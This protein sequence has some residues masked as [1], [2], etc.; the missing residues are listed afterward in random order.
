MGNF[1]G[2]QLP[3]RPSTFA[4]GGSK[5]RGKR[6]MAFRTRR[7]R[8]RVPV[9]WLPN[10]G[11]PALRNT[12]STAYANFQENPAV[13]EHHDGFNPA[14]NT[15]LEFPLL[16]DNPPLVAETGGTLVNYEKQS[17]NFTEDIGYSL[18][19]IVGNIYVS[20]QQIPTE[21]V[22]SGIAPAWLVTAGLIVRRVDSETGLPLA[23][24]EDEDPIAIQNNQDPWIW[25]RNWILGSFTSQQSITSTLAN[26]VSNFPPSNAFIG[27]GSVRE[28][29]FVD[30]KT[31]RWVGPEERLIL[32]MSF[33]A[34]PLDVA[35]DPNNFQLT[36][37]YILFVH[38]VLGTKRYNRGNRNN[39]SR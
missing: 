7:R 14:I 34:L 5:G 31:R 25:R 10:V 8:K 29:T 39:A 3:A 19:R 2:A 26:A 27:P 9:V 38:R 23:Q 30:Q 37:M 17:L 24:L 12:G 1:R 4:S 28:G 18:R 33:Q 32:N 6:K 21:P 16:I 35:Y 11:T 20:S 13:L 15:I 22:A 36:D